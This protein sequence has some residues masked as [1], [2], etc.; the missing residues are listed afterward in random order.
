MQETLKIYGAEWCGDCKRSKQFLDKHGVQYE[1]ID[2]SQSPEARNFVVKVNNGKQIIPTIVFPNGS[3][4]VEP[5]DRELGEKL[6]IK[7]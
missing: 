5:S 7:T 3:F 6:G 1:W 4:L 2:V